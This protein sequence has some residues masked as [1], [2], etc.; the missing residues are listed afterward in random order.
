MDRLIRYL[1]IVSDA[2]RVEMV[3]RGGLHWVELEL[4]GGE[5]AIPAQR[6]VFDLLT[7]VS[8]CRWSTGRDLRPQR[9]YFSHAAPPSA[10]AISD[11]ESAFQS[12]VCFN[13]T[14]NGL[15]FNAADL[16]LP[17]LSSNPDFSEMHDRFAVQRLEQLAFAQ[18]NCRAR[19]I[20]IRR[21]PEGEPRREDIAVALCMS[22]RTLY[23]RLQLEGMTFQQLLDDTRRELAQQYLRQK[24]LPLAQASY[25]LG[26]ADQSNFFRACK[27]W[28][29]VSPGRYRSQFVATPPSMA[30]PNT[31]PANSQKAR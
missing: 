28:F 23:R 12:T 21:L 3:K 26:F 18:T 13:R 25:L 5:A 15:G 24:N 16:A 14:I 31:H 8:F 2:A 19:E 10:T 4:F 7:L 20:I 22:D 29:D 27:R 30:L 1:Q 9:V 17:M 11:Y 6:I